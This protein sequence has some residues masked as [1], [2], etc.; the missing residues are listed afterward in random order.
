VTFC[1][2]S[3]PHDI[4]RVAIHARADSSRARFETRIVHG[5]REHG[6]ELRRAVRYS[7]SASA[8]FSWGPT[9]LDGMQAEGITRDISVQGA[10][11][12]SI[13]CPPL[14]GIVELELLLPPLRG[15]IPTSSIKT[16]GRVLRV[17]AVADGLARWGF[18]VKAERFEVGSEK[19][20]DLL[21]RICRERQRI[22]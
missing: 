4:A 11:V 18:A 15:T 12:Y 14:K 3:H 10:Y 2:L 17:E 5:T 20:N 9:H 1:F 22:Y 13:G 16:K 8:L 21:A 6:S 7:V 19:V